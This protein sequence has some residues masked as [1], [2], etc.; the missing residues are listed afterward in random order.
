MH[1][2]EKK[3]TGIYSTNYCLAIPTILLIGSVFKLLTKLA[4]ESIKKPTLRKDQGQD[5]LEFSLDIQC[6][7][8]TVLGLSVVGFRQKVHFDN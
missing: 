4:Y 7:N 5:D 6:F 8:S 2:P 3:I 1:H